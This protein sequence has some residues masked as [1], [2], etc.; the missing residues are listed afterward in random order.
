MTGDWAA[1]GDAIRER[2]AELKMSTAS[3]ARETGLSETTIRYISQPGPGH[4]RSTLV[5]ISAV[6]RWRYDHLINIL[7][8]ESHKNIPVK[9]TIGEHL[10][11]IEAKLD[12]IAEQIDRIHAKK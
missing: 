2:R 9:R 1:V 3:L 12:A 4:N 8:G 5:A 10:A 11:I 6:L 7:H